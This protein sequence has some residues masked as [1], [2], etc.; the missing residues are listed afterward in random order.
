MCYGQNNILPLGWTN[1]TSNCLYFLICKGLLSMDTWSGK[2]P[3]MISTSMLVS[4]GI[5]NYAQTLTTVPNI[6]KWLSLHFTLQYCQLQANS[7]Y[8]TRQLPS[9]SD[10][11]R[12]HHSDQWMVGSI[13][14]LLAVTVGFQLWSIILTCVFFLVW[15]TRTQLMAPVA[16]LVMTPWHWPM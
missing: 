6:Y 7:M 15:W 13:Q 9:C 16:A 1:M 4:I 11:W 5:Q 8:E 2:L 3:R 14:H 10:C 12:H